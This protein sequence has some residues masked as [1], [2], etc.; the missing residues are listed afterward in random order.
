[1]VR[2]TRRSF[3]LSAGC[4]AA[5][6]LVI[7]R[8]S[9]SNE[10]GPV[11]LQ[12]PGEVRELI[13]R[14][15]QAI[16]ATMAKENI[17]GAAVC[18]VHDGKLAWLEAFG[19]TDKHSNRAVD[20]NTI[21]S[22]QSTSKNLTATAIMLAVQRGFLDL[23]KPITAYLPKFTVNS[24]FESQPE[25]KITLRTLLS[26]RAGFTHESAVGN[27]Y[28][29]TAADFNSHVDS[30]SQTWLR[31]PVNDRYRY[32]NLGFDLAGY[33]LQAVIGKP[34]TECLRSLLFSPLGMNDATGDARDYAK[35]VNRAVGHLQGHERVPVEIPIIPSGGI[36]V[37]AR[38][39]AAYLL[40]HVNKGKADNKTLLKEAL[41]NEMHAFAYP[42]SYSLGVAGGLLRFGETDI[43]MLMHSGSGYGFGC[44][45]RFYPQAKVGWALLFNR[46]VGSAY[47]LGS[48]VTDELLTRRYGRRTPR[49]MFDALPAITLP[50]TELQKLVGNWRGRGYSRDF[51]LV[52]GALVVDGDER[53][54]PIRFTSP[55]Q[56]ASP[57]ERPGGDPIQLRYFREGQTPAHLEPLLTDI[58]LDY[59]DGPNDPPGPDKGI[60]EK[61]VGDYS[62]DQWGRPLYPIKV[63]R[64]NGYL[65]IDTARMV[66]EHEPG[67]FFTSDGESV[68]FRATNLRWGNIP[69]RRV[70]RA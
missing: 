63:H 36:Y 50:Q 27:N 34:F 70:S 39:M 67:L 14:E 47:Q 10:T 15:R 7:P 11:V 57:P 46:A 61:Y 69:L 30:I 43:R 45:L 49:I 29:N 1:M 56:I 37:S 28:D 32:S 35:R 42:G 55:D 52:D 21:F 2:R 65:Y 6:S 3:V 23:D 44:M 54:T 68:D 9:M 53:R 25:K 38:D 24:R 26:H 5:A 20:P 12:A 13:E 62:I 60:W 8:R 33:I 58:H 31:C 4:A 51:R 18:F 66:V 40:L 59:N 16:L 22:I 48:G 17:P 19:V 41:W 64:K